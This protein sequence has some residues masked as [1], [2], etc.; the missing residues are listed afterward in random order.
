M[1]TGALVQ[2]TGASRDRGPARD[3]TEVIAELSRHPYGRTSA[4]P[5]ETA[6]LVSLAPWLP[7]HADR[8]R[9]LLAGQRPD[10]GWGG[11][12]GYA[13]VP[14][15]SAVEGLLATLLR[16]EPAGWSPEAVS[17]AVDRGLRL[18]FDR[19]TGPATHPVPDLPAAD[20]IVPALVD[21]IADH[22]A[23]PPTRLV[24]WRGV[25]APAMPDALDRQR[26]DRVRLLLG[27][28]R[29]ITPK[30][31]HALEVLGP[32]ARGAA[33]V[34]ATA[35]GPVGASPAAT[36]AWL[37]DPDGTQSATLDYLIRAADEHG[38]AVPCATPITVFE[39][40][41]VLSTLARAGVFPTVPP[42][43]LAGLRDALGPDGAATGP[44]LPTDADT[45]A[46]TLYALALLGHPADP[47]CLGRFDAGEHFGTWQGEDGSSVTTNAHVLE[48][49]GRC[50]GVGGPS[51]APVLRRLT[52]WL[53]D[54]QEPDGRWSDRWH[55][56]PYYATYC[57]TLALREYGGPSAHHAV[58][59]AVS[60]VLDTQRADGSWGRWCGT[61]EET[62]YGLLVLLA[63]PPS[64]TIRAAGVA[65]AHRL[66]TMQDE[67]TDHPLWHD[68]DL[69]HP[70]VIV[71]ATVA[72]ARVSAA[73]R[74]GGSAHIPDSRWSAP[75]E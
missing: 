63:A 1:S 32:A 19:A 71:R 17:D 56:S 30:L 24:H 16:D 40:A 60:W 73:A 41:W 72:A 10:G 49:F 47:S 33:G 57:V 2:D 26:L 53:L 18:L 52:G 13:L 51:P 67:R 3:V 64:S 4:S 66:S 44:G 35:A 55:A 11:P 28:G 31:L 22:L 50:V 48:A 39:R 69:Y 45:T 21:R 34:T 54:R 29:P 68:K 43:L 62:A 27:S 8:I 9:Y 42:E 65:A 61:A 12:D 38:G 5:Y 23:D 59:R 25:G 74:L 70:A 6:R 15:L 75:L 58:R 36:A 7:R 46:V 20:L 14:T 37:G